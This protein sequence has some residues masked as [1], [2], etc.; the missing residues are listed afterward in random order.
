MG[1]LPAA[2]AERFEREL[3]LSEDA[4]SHQLAFRGELGD[5]LEQADGRHRTHDAR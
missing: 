3:G 2:R 5:F 1:E 4:R